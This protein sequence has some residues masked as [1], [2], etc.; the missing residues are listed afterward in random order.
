MVQLDPSAITVLPS[1][2]PFPLAALLPCTS[3]AL[4]PPMMPSVP[5]QALGL[6][7]S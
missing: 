3:S 4:Q 6:Y 5:L 1:L 2:P 7:Q